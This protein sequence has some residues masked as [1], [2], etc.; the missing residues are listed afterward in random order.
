MTANKTGYE[1]T[2]RQVAL[3]AVAPAML[4]WLLIPLSDL[5]SRVDSTRAPYFDLT[6]TLSTV[7]YWI[8]Q[9]GGRFGAPVVAALM[10]T[11]LVARSGITSR[12]RWREAGVIAL[13]ALFF[14]GGG[15]A[16]SVYVLKQQFKVPR[17][18]IVWLAG[19]HG[20]GPL[21]MTPQEFYE[22]GSKQDRRELL[23][24]TLGGVPRPVTLSPAIEAHWVAETGYSFPSGH[25]FSAMFF[26]TFFLALGVTY[27]TTKRLWVLYALLP[28]AVA[29]CYSR[30]ILRVHTPTDLTVG[31][32][33]GF[34]AGLLAWAVAHKL[35]RRFARKQ[36]DNKVLQ[37]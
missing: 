19:N 15:S 33:L 9:S 13:I 7:V 23:A 35:N 4:A 6:N 34:T 25:A 36:T 24:K 16:L 12:R 31:G 20:S 8:T 21:G 10:L 26:A 17:P 18:N 22:S 14:G 2:T 1:A 27:L 29:V 32:F 28:W 30:S 11:L 5:L 3:R 37:L